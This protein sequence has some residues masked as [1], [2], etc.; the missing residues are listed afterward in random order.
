MAGKPCGPRA[1]DGGPPIKPRLLAPF[2][3]L[4]VNLGGISECCMPAGRRESTHVR[5][6]AV[7]RDHHP[8][9][10]PAQSEEHRCH[11][12]AG[13]HDRDHRFV[14]IGQIHPCLRHPLCRGPAPVCG[15]TVDLRPPVS[16]AHGKTRCRSHRG[17]VAGH[18]HRAEN[19]RPQPAFHGGNGDGNIR[20][21]A[22]ALCPRG[23]APLPPVRPSDLRANH[24]PNG[25]PGGIA[26]GRIAPHHPGPARQRRERQPT[27]SSSSG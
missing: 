1:G 15:I 19:G 24:R 23:D 26:A 17:A 21:P 14:R 5:F 22:A 20:L 9:R 13:P 3:L 4:Q 8:R 2:R 18:R 27:R 7:T 10:P 25:R 12:P 16:G 6:Y 11:D